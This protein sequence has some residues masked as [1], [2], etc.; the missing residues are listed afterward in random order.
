MNE[1]RIIKFFSLDALHAA[2]EVEGTSIYYT[3]LANLKKIEAQ[4]SL[5]KD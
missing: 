1:Q 4:L 3:D 2:V 5:L